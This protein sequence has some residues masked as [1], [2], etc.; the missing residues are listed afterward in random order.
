MKHSLSVSPFDQ[1]QTFFT[2]TGMF[3]KLL[4]WVPP[5][6]QSELTP[7]Q[8]SIVGSLLEELER[9]RRQSTSGFQICDITSSS[10]FAGQFQP[11]HRRDA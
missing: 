3:E 6:P 10:R 4:R 9:D 2:T 11:R 7:E 8:F 1:K 5:S